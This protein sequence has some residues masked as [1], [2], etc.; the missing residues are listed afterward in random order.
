MPDDKKIK[1]IIFDANKAIYHVP[2]DS[3]NSILEHVNKSKLNKYLERYD[4][5]FADRVNLVVGET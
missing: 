3:L 2:K 1:L 4:K 5:R